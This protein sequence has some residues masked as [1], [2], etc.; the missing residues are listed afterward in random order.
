[1]MTFIFNM[2]KNSLLV[3]AVISLQNW[4]NLWLSFIH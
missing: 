1:M 3:L 2:H 4:S